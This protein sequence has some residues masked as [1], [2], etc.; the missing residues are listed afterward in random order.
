MSAVCVVLHAGLDVYVPA[1][2]GGGYISRERDSRDDA[3]LL[4][5][6][7]VAL[8]GAGGTLAAAHEGK[9]RRRS[10]DH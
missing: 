2:A 6:I 9:E 3:R 8:N 4:Q 7:R 10:L 5:Q 1:G